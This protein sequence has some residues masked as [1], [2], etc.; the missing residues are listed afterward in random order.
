[1]NKREREMGEMPNVC[2]GKSLS[3]TLA[4]RLD[5]GTMPG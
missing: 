3:G 1:M 5:S 4:L 2:S